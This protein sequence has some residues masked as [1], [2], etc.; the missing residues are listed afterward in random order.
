MK[1]IALMLCTVLLSVGHAIGQTRLALVLATFPDAPAPAPWTMDQARA[2]AAEIDGGPNGFAAQSYGAMTTVTDVFGI[3]TIAR[4]PAG[5]AW[6]QT[7]EAIA[8]DIQNALLAADVD[9]TAY[10]YPGCLAVPCAGHFAYV[11][12]GTNA[13]G[14]GTNAG[15][16]MGTADDVRTP[17]LHHVLHELGHHFEGWEHDRGSTCTGALRSGTCTT[18]GQGDSLSVMGHG[19]GH[20]SPGA[21]RQAGW[22]FPIDVTQSGD[23]LIAP[24]DTVGGVKALR[25][26]GGTNKLPTPYLLTF[27]PADASS[28]WVDPTNVQTGVIVHLDVPQSP[29][30]LWGMN[31]S[32]VTTGGQNTHPALTIGQVWCEQG[33]ALSIAPLSVGP[34]GILVRIDTRR[35][36]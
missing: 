20:V 12:P 34:D 7:Q 2:R 13:S 14:M 29:S 35:C 28:S 27:R 26:F 19:D 8:T 33:K 18:H 30:V 31:P 36:K 5:L 9:L 21:K 4:P 32:S 10:A 15:V 1:V 24:Y 17:S 23:Y 22:L 11:T 6:W 25:V 16:W 3:V